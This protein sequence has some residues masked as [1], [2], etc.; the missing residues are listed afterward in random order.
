MI[1]PIFFVPNV[2]FLIVTTVW[3]S[4][5]DFIDG[6]LARKWRVATPFG[7]KLDQYSDK[8]VTFFLGLFFINQHKL[9]L[10]FG[11]IILV[12]EVLILFL[13]KWNW[14]V[15]QSNFIGKL[16]TAL[17]YILFILLS[18]DFIILPIIFD[19]KLIVMSLIIATSLLS[20][21]LS[22]PVFAN[23]LLFCVGTTGFSSIVFNK[24]PGTISSFV[25]FLLL[26][27]GLKEL[28]FEYKITVLLILLLIHFSYY[29]EFVEQT[30]SIDEDPGIYT[31][32]ETIAIVVAWVFMI[33]L[34]LT[35]VF[36]LFVLF[37]FFDIFKPLGI[38]LVESQPNYNIAFTN[39]ADD[40]IAILYSLIIF[41]IL[42][43]YV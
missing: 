31:L 27:V 11:I 29:K 8:I 7:A 39:L 22:I 40:I 4:L 17:L 3:I 9:P 20:L 16:K 15:S 33:N 26:F 36:L 5:S 28:A 13:R 21:I 10:L 25:I 42:F 32:D 35:H 12:R 18:I 1:F 2:V 34:P 30:N 43:M 14:A 37:R 6:Y 41:Q 24:A 38:K 19:L 23:K